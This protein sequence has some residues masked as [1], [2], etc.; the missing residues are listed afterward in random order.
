MVS[1]EPIIIEAK[2]PGKLSGPTLLNIE[3]IIASDPLPE[4]GRKNI[5]GTTSPGIPKHS[6]RG[7]IKFVNISSA[8]EAL[9]I[10]TATIRPIKAGAID[11]VEERPF[12]APSVNFSNKGTFLKKPNDTINSTT[13]G[14]M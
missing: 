6:V 2:R 4:I 3:S 14:T 12:F 10:E 13:I 7:C 11:T 5:R 8:P 9:I 1:V